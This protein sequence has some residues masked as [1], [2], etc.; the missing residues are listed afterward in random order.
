LRLFVVIPQPPHDIYLKEPFKEGLRIKVKMVIIS[1]PQKTLVEMA[2]L[3]NMIEE[4]MLVR[5]KNIIIYC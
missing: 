2:E 1:M 4:E 3:A 5:R